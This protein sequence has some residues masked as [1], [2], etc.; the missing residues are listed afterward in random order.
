MKK[1]ELLLTHIA[2]IF[3]FTLSSCKAEKPTDVI[4]T[5]KPFGTPTY[6]HQVPPSYAPGYAHFVPPKNFDFHLE[7]YY[8][9]YWFLNAY[10]DEYGAAS[11][12]LGDPGFLTLPTPR[13][14]SS[15]TM[16]PTPNDFGSVF[17]WIMPKETDRTPA[18]EL[19][20]HKQSY[21]ETSRMKVLRD[22]KIT[23]DT[24]EAYI[25]EYQVDDPETSP[26]VMFNRRIFFMVEDQVYEIMFEV[27]EKDRNGEFEKGFDHFLSS[28][29]ILH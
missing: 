6:F 4:H 11:V 25:L 29:V 28:I 20:S 21:S 5:P 15:D 12:F 8:P 13:P 26:S 18:A 16:H 2:M 10:R 24:S 9:K 22:Y 3:V 7:F 17:I 27:A 14:N 19:E 23:I 1:I